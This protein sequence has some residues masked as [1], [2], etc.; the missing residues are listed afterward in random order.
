MGNWGCNNC[1]TM[2]KGVDCSIIKVKH[3]LLL[4]DKVRWSGSAVNEK[5][6]KVFPLSPVEKYKFLGKLVPSDN[7]YFI[8]WHG[9]LDVPEHISAGCS[10]CTL[11]QIF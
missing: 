4:A 10:D 2:A 3:N 9:R 6:R 5:K 7:R 11:G 1:I 8:D